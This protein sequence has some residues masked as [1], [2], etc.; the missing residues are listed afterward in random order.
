MEDKYRL[1]EASVQNEEVDIEFIAKEFKRLRKKEAHILREDFGG[2][3]ALAIG[4]VQQSPKNI[5]YSIDLDPEPFNYSKAVHFPKLTENEKTRMN[6]IQAN[7]LS[8]F[9][10]KADII[11]AFNF[12]YFIFK[13]RKELLSYFRKAYEGL[14]NGGIFFIDLF[15]GKECYGEIEEETE[16][17]LHSYFWDLSR[18]DAITNE[19][20]YY[21]HFSMDGKKYEKVFS[22]DW[23]MWSLIELREILEEVGFSKTICYWEG[24]EEGDTGEGNGI[25]SPSE[26]EENCE[27]WVSYIAALK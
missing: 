9:S 3:S 8:D 18:F 20:M 27:S 1:Y 17:D 26:S 23:R 7:V 11:V 4:W 2:T 25:Y 16:H 13:K 24:D 19:V 10:F 21:I 22:Y 5:S 15:G 12:S 14:E 6:Y